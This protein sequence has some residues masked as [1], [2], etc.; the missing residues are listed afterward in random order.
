GL[1]EDQPDLRAVG[2]A[3]RYS[4]KA[5]DR[6]FHRYIRAV[7]YFAFDRKTAIVDECQALAFRVLESQNVPPVEGLN[8]VLGYIEFIE[9]GRPVIQCIS[10]VDPELR[11]DYAVRAASVWPRLWPIEERHVRAGGTQLVGIEKVI[12]R[13]VVLVNRFFNKPQS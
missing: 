8:G 13:G 5:P 9:P 12:R 3:Q 6:V 10:P 11:V 7:P 1:V 4:K 2:H